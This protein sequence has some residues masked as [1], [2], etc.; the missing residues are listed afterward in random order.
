[1]TSH[2]VYLPLRSPTFN[3][4]SALSVCNCCINLLYI[5]KLTPHIM[6]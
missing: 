3:G 5:G 1:M 2:A 4:L 6:R